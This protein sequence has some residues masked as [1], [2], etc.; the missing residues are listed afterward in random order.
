[1]EHVRVLAGEIGARG[2]CTEAEQRAAEYA[3]DTMRALGAREVTVERFRAVP[4]TYRP[5]AVA[6]GLALS[7]TAV[8]WMWPGRLTLALAALAHLAA[9]W[10]MIRESDLRAS[11]MRRLLPQATGHNA[12]GV[13]PAAGEVRRRAVVCAH[14]DTHRTPVFYSSDTWQR[15]FG[16]LVTGAFASLVAGIMVY[17]LGALL[18][19][20]WVYWIG[21]LTGSVQM[22]LLGLSIQAEFTPYSPGANDNASG[23]GV[24]LGLAERLAREPLDHTEV[25]LALTDCEEVMAQGMVSFVDARGAALGSDAMYVI[26]DQVGAGHLTWLSVDGLILKHETHPL[27]LDLARRAAAALPE[28]KSEERPGVAYTDAVVATKRGVPAITLSAIPKEGGAGAHWHQMS[29]RVD[30]V[31]RSSLVDACA[32]AWL[33]LRETDRMVP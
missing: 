32:F 15:L 25:W 5:Y 8:A 29:D 26:L 22:A 10:G 1:M 33:V 16:L 27:A 2:S 30:V 19:W 23:V 14:L 24:A 20:T 4:G 18:D 31:Q 13:M 28:I 3:A 7:G 9:A 17:G 12:V 11:W 21:L 6:F